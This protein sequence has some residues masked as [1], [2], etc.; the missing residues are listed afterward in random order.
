MHGSHAWVPGSMVVVH[1]FLVPWWSCIGS[2]FHGGRAW[3][4]GSMVV[5]HRF[6]VPWWSCIGSWF[7]GGCSWF[8]VGRAWDPGSMLVV[9]G[10]RY[11]CLSLCRFFAK[12]LYYRII[13]QPSQPN[14]NYFLQ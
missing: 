6:L 10:Y 5:V 7:H 9:H 2:W 3:V 12:E 4:P 13:T 11:I 14:A 8:H 1:R